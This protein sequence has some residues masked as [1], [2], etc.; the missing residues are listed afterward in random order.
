[1]PPEWTHQMTTPSIYMLR[2]FDNKVFRKVI[3]ST[4]GGVVKGFSTRYV[5]G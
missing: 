4:Q 3:E 5:V 2:M 1:M